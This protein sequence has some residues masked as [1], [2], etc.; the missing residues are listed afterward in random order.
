M[1]RPSLYITSSTISFYRPVL[2]LIIKFLSNVTLVLC[3]L[4][5]S[6]TS[7]D[8]NQDR[9][10]QQYIAFNR[11]ARQGNRTGNA[12]LPFAQH[13]L[14][15]SL[16]TSIQKRPNCD[17]M[18]VT[19]VNNGAQSTHANQRPFIRK[20]QNFGHMFLCCVSRSYEF[21]DTNAMSSS[22]SAYSGCDS[23]SSEARSV[24]R[25]SIHR[26]TSVT[27][28]MAD[29]DFERS[30]TPSTGTGSVSKN[31]MG[32]RSSEDQMV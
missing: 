9:T 6:K 21:D 16:V 2:L 18:E 14:S 32:G 20:L 13:V 17:N 23:T 27:E 28:A 15:C 5:H 26:P 10:M 4:F 12:S 11:C 30:P 31:I 19:F 1:W 7:S 25:T 29:S 22:S 24:I 8:P 3:N